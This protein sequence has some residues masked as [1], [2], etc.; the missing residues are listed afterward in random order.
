MLRAHHPN[1]QGSSGRRHPGFAGNT[2]ATPFLFV[3][4]GAMMLTGAYPGVIVGSRTDS[5]S[6]EGAPVRL[7]SIRVEHTTV[8]RWPIWDPWPE[9]IGLRSGCL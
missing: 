6:L 8:Q 1:R 3:G 4:L 5:V 7:G 9:G 2:A